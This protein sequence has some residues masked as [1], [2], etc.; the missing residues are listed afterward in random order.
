M[1]LPV[2]VV[3]LIVRHVEPDD[4]WV[5]AL[6]ARVWRDATGSTQT[7]ANGVVGSIERQRLARRCGC[8]LPRRVLA[9][10]AGARGVYGLPARPAWSAWLARLSAWARHAVRAAWRS[11]VGG[12]GADDRAA[13]FGAWRRAHLWRRRALDRCAAAGAAHTG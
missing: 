8:R 2:D 3:G 5:C 13:A 9:W 12:G 10:S 4:R 7:T 1:D 11:V 6:V